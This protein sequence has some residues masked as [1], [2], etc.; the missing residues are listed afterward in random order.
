MSQPSLEE[1]QQTAIS[2]IQDAGENPT[3][4]VSIGSSSKGTTVVVFINE[5]GEKL[6]AEISDTSTRIFEM[7]D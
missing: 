2:F 4:I 1:L 7:N 5:A 6:G 3:E